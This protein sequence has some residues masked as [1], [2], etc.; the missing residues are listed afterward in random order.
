MIKLDNSIASMIT[1]ICYVVVQ[2]K[3]S[4]TSPARFTGLLIVFFYVG[5]D[6]F[7]P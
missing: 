1:G 7:H 4:V 5:Y 3:I 2:K 6:L